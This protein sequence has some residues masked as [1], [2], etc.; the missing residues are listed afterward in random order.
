[1]SNLQRAITQSSALN[2]GEE[3]HDFATV[4]FPICRS[5]TGN[6][7]RQ[8]LQAIGAKIPLKLHEVPSGTPVFDWAVPKEW[9]VRDAYIADEQGTKLV[10]FRKSNLH[11][12]NYSVPIRA[13]M[14]YAE[15]KAHLHTIPRHPTWIPYRTSYYKEDWGF[16][17][18]HEQAEKLDTNAS[19]EV[20][21]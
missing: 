10:D 18:S 14:S 17:L 8:T 1:M 12:M 19:Y 5:I 11:V 20:L 9:N 15:L 13:T 7:L 16:C 2:I 21:Y 3:L 4:L 6:G